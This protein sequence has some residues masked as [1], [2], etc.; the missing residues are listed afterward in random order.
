MARLTEV[1]SA[2]RAN[3][4]SR[5]ISLSEN[6][7]RQL[8]ELTGERQDLVD[9]LAEAQAQL[10]HMGAAFTNEQKLQKNTGSQ[11]IDKK[12]KSSRRTGSLDG[13]QNGV[14]SAKE[15]A[16]SQVRE[17]AATGELHKAHTQV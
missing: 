10:A 9:A 12:G 11:G 4:D 6:L 3:S 14:E 1:C 5:E 15:L 2:A 16:A 7:R 13:T 8:K 17:A